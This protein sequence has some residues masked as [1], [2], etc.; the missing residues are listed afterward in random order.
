M[1]LSLE[2]GSE[3]YGQ[4]ELSGQ[5][6]RQKEDIGHM[7]AKSGP[8]FHIEHIGQLIESNETS[9]RA[10]FDAIYLKKTEQIMC[11]GRSR[12][13]FISKEDKANIKKEFEQRHQEL[14][15]GKIEG[16]VYEEK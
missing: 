3:D 7:D 6:V 15:R 2:S 1:M 8:E 14:G 9:M 13:Q 12:K 10:E 5:L 4:I 16:N 11:S